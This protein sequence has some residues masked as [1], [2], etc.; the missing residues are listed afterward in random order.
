MV[1]VCIVYGYGVYSV[2][3]VMVCIVYGY[4]VYSVW[5]WCVVYGVQ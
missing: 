3:M 5:L 4:G 2:C 1:M